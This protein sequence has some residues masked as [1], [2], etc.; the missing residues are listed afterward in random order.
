MIAKDV[1]SLN[2]HR[3]SEHNFVCTTES[4]LLYGFDARFFTEP[5]FTLQAHKK[6]CSAA[7][8]S[9][10]I[11]NLLATVGTDS[12]CKIWDIHAQ[13]PEGKNEP[14]LIGKRDLQQGDLFSVKFYEDI[15]WVLAAGGANGEIAI[16]DIEESPEISSHFSPNLDPNAPKQPEA[17]PDD[18]NEDFE[19]VSEE[20]EEP[21]V[22]VSKKKSKN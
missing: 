5:I 14:R 17:I 22:K 16:W 8:F 21:V 20:E 9:P 7:S 13:T 12:V 1:E 18:G 15:P 11:P 19:D 10:H 3:T 6:A 4:G 2:W